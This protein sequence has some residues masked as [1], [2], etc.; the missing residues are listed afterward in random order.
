MI[1]VKVPGTS[2][3]MGPGFDSLGLAINIYN[4]F[5][6]KEIED[7][8]A[9][10]G[11]EDE[12]MNQENL[13]YKSMKKTF[14]ILGFKPSGVQIKIVNDIPI[15]RGLGSSASCII[16]GIL[17]ANQMAKGDL[18]DEDIISIAT[19]IEGHPDNVVPAYTGGITVSIME[20]KKVYYNRINLKAD[21]KLCALIPDYRLSTKMARDVLPKS[22]SYTDG[23]FNI[24]RAAFLVSALNNGDMEALRVACQDRIHQKFRGRL[25]ENYDE[26]IRKSIELG[27]IA[28]FLSGAGPTIMVVVKEQDTFI[29][30]MKEF[31]APLNGNWK[32][33]PLAIDVKGAMVERI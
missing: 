3:N 13:I 23:I 15:S 21:L 31:L 25:I 26:I 14:D 17:G 29:N 33:R 24:S 27:C 12:F 19:E 18:K 28:T 4:T 11:C 5:Y 32:I 1:K 16:G 30:N 8:I 20:N 6:F 9:I 2:A 7:E 10:E 22:I